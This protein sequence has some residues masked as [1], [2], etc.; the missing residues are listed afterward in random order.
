M[1]RWSAPPAASEST[2]EFPEIRSYM[3]IR[4]YAL[5][6]DCHGSALVA[7]DGSVDW[8]CLGR[9]DAVPVFWRI[10]DAAKGGFF[11]VCPDG[12]ARPERSYEPHTNVLQT[13]FDAE[14]GKIA[15]TDFMPV[16][17]VPGTGDYAT[18]NAP[19][20]FV[21]IVSGVEGRVRLRVQFK[22][23]A[24]KFSNPQGEPGIGSDRGEAV[25][26]NGADT[27]DRYLDTRIE[28]SAGEQHTFIIA[29]RSTACS[30]ACFDPIKL[31]SITRSF[32][33]EWIARCHYQGP[34]NE[35]VHRSAL[36]LKLLTYAPTGAVIAA[37]T[38]SLPET[39]GGE[40][41]WDYRFSWIR[42]S[43]LI[44]NALAALG[45][46][47]E[48]RRFCEFQRLCC[49]KTLPILQVMYGI[50]GDTE[51]PERLLD[52]IDGYLGS[53]PVR[54]GNGAYR[55][56]Q[57]D[58]Y[59]EV[60]DWILM[61]RALGQQTDATQERMIRG[62]ADYVAANWAEPD[63]GI[64]EIRAEPRHHV[65]S[66]LMSWVALDRAIQLCGEVRSW[67]EARDAILRVILERG[68]DPTG[69]HLVQA[70]SVDATD[71]ALLLTPT[72]GVPLDP[73]LLARTVTAVQ[74]ELQEGDYV[75]RYRT[76]DGLSGNE[77]AFL[78]CSFWLVDALLFTGRAEEARALFERLLVQTNDI[79]LYAEE[80]DPTTG[81]F[82]GNFPQGFT[83]LALISS[84]ANFK[85]FEDGGAQALT[86]SYA[87]RV[88]RAAK[89][90]GGL[91]TLAP[92]STSTRRTSHAS[93]LPHFGQ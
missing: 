41:N 58:I 42:D 15:L 71:A 69:D 16:G 38:T 2:G 80:I 73:S 31:L 84:A 29:P 86:G 40:R 35:A 74:R 57:T 34:Y 17:R 65:H 59:G 77:G 32:W 7:K 51:L 28:I 37:P 20:W 21:R 5:V 48:A 22:S 78:I 70:F 52:H 85:I 13:T 66:K 49:I 43:S 9:F 67:A 25:L 19:G 89:V 18:L 6:G 23:A 68:L 81:A 33:A 45:Y 24:A 14:S 93:E 53:R 8:C 10:L 54:V 82:L 88:R 60:M 63:H 39:P 62:I 30:V 27:F 46:D 44:L 1:N 83:H 11:Q 26:V 76:P 79:G 47:G 36:V 50:G 61:L 75:R 55:Q 92:L 3:P 64:W 12:P 90:T 72:L 91:R 56:R 4:D 87:D